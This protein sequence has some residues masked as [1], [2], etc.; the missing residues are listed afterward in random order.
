MYD[1]FTLGAL[2]SYVHDLFRRNEIPTVGKITNEFPKRMDLPSFVRHLL[3][4]IGF[5]PEKRSRNS[6]L[7]DQEDIAEWRNHYLRDMERY[8]AEGRKI[9]F[10]D[11]AWLM[12]V[13]TRTI[14]WT[15][16]V[17]QKRGRLFTRA[18]GL[19][20]GLKKPSGKGLCL[21]MTHVGSESR[22][23]D[24]CLNVFRGRKTGDYHEEMDEM[25]S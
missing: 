24:D 22:F 20:T 12:V 15:D 21:I 2:R 11:E 18:Y 14:M 6:L 19:S 16:S 9:F 4:E 8:V 13:H 1:S 10:L 3:A 7:I 5:R 17:L 25:A 23:V